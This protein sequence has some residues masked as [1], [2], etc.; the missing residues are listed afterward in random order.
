MKALVLAAGLGTRF[1]SSLPKVLHPILGKP[2]LWYVLDTLK[3]A[4][5]KDV[6]FVVN[7]GEELVRKTFGEEVSYFRQENPKGGTADAVKSAL[8]FFQDYE[9]YI[10]II[11]GDSPL[12]SPETV[13]NMQRFIH[14]TEEYEKVSLGGVVL[15]AFLQDPTG[16]GRIIKEEGTDRIL[17]IVEEKDADPRERNIKEVN[18]GVYIFRCDLLAEA[19]GEIEPSGVTGELYLPEVVRKLSE[20]GIEVRSFMAQEPTEI[21]GVNTRWELSFAE[22]IIRLK[23]IRFWAQ[24]G[25]TFHLPE[26]IWIEPDVEIEP[27]SEIFQGAVL[28]GK[29]VVRS[30]AKVLPYTIL[31]DSEVKE[32]AT[33]GPFAHIRMGSVIGQASEI[34]NFVEVKN[35][36]IGKGVKAKHLAY[37]G[38]AEVGDETNIGAGSITANFDGK[39]KHK[40]YIGKKVFVGSNS[41]LVAPIRLGD[42]SYIAGGS[43]IT[44]DVPQGALALERAQLKIFDGKGKSKLEG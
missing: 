40:T 10:L 30:K 14:M 44:K 18:G 6:A 26:T 33:V 15:T 17:R 4:N 12:V 42:L 8:K 31:E 20:K 9:G 25:V 22:N 39:K 35:S 11:N 27:D 2:M 19:L 32:G 16:Y 43:V 38:D 36:K 7:H 29:T 13:K 1:R 37:L 34:G 5:I 3:K 41:L 21:L 23:L 24:K 28:K